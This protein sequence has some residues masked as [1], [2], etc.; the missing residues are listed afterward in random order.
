MGQPFIVLGDRTD[1]GGVVIGGTIG[2]DVHGK[3]IARIRDMVSCPRCKGVFPISQ[4]DPSMVIDGAPTAYHGCRTACGAALLSSQAVATT[5]PSGGAGAGA[6]NGLDRTPA[7]PHGFGAI[8]S[9][10]LAGYEDEPLDDA[11]QRFRGRFQV[12]DL[13]SGEPLAIQS[14]RVRSTGGQSFTGST[15]AEGFT[16]WVE[17]DAGEVLA[18]DVIEPG[19]A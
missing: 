2:S 7:A 13:A 17:R 8:G 16:Q 10:L 4:G 14:V 3:R 1:H 6:T 9:G 11:H 19:Q 12:L 18:F 15:D 5:T